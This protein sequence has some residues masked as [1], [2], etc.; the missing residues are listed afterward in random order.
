MAFTLG[1]DVYGTLINT[2][3]VFQS[4]QSMLG[5]RAEPLMNLWRSK[6][7]EYSFRR[8]LMER[9]TDF[10]VCTRDALIYSCNTLQIDMSA[11][12]ADSL[13]EEY[14]SLPAFPEVEEALK[15]C[16]KSGFSIYAF[17][18]GSLSAIETLMDHAGIT[19]LFDGLISTEDVRM[20]KPS[21]KVYQHFLDV[22]G[23]DQKS[24]WLISGNPFD[25]I[26]ALS[27]GMQSAWVQR[28]PDIVF[29][30]WEYS[31][32][33]TAQDLTELPGILQSRSS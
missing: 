32:T 19:E 21:P 28:S 14:K 9:H 12:Q 2:A 23:S 18:N 3:G 11:G 33:V 10:S 27:F 24:S 7:L 16:R 26:G 1:F 29:D 6:Q 13:M 31:P 17:S 30:P 4:L 15:A 20:F 22:T 25:V 5:K 8:G